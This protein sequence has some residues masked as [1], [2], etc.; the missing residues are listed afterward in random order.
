MKSLTAILK[1]YVFKYH[2]QFFIKFCVVGLIAAFVS[3]SVFFIL[4]TS[5]FM[6][7]IYASLFGNISGLSVGFFLN[8]TWT[9]EVEN[10]SLFLLV[11]YLSFYMFSFALNVSILFLFVEYGK[12]NPLIS[13]VF[14][15]GIC[16]FVNFFGVKILVFKK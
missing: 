8:K 6:Y 2:L 1:Y 12:I 14:S 3:Y 9:F 10:R 13:N 16:A 11:K 5:F 7:Y 4:Y 15:I